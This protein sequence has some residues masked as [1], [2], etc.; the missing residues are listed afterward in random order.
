MTDISCGG[1]QVAVAGGVPL[2]VGPPEGW[3]FCFYYD[4]SLP[5]FNKQQSNTKT[6]SFVSTNLK[7]IFYVILNLPNLV[8]GVRQQP[9]LAP[10]VIIHYGAPVNI[11]F[12]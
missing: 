1:L 4:I 2:W 8:Q 5:K 6:S 11:L 12:T 10:L 9:L 7:L 3:N